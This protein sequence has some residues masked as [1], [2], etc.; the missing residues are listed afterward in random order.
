MQLAIHGSAPA[1]DHVVG[2]G[3]A[4]AE[5]AR[6]LRE[7]VAAGED[8]L[9]T[10]W[11]TR[12][13]FRELP[14]LLGWL[15]AGSV[16]RWRIEMLRAHGRFAADPRPWIPRLGMAVPHALAA[17]AKAR[18][19][20]IAATIRGVPRC[21]LGPHGGWADPGEVGGFGPR[22]EGCGVRGQ[23]EGVGAWYLE[24]FGADELRPLSAPSGPG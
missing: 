15:Q 14:T 12:S 4:H 5:V 7:A 24:R 6:R 8:V 1:H 13:T 20:G 17:I 19:L 21:L 11:L 16:K 22:C 10:T 3:G 2:R 18:K 9:V 23:C